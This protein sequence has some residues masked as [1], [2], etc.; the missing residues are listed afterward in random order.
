MQ[1]WKSNIIYIF[2]R[3]LETKQKTTNYILTYI[4]E[5]LIKLYKKESKKSFAWKTFNF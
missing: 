2:E 5:H 3:H 1:Q 4:Q